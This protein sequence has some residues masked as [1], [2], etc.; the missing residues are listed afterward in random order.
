MVVPEVVVPEALVL[1]NFDKYS[2]KRLLLELLELLELELSELD[3]P[4][5]EEMES[6][7]ASSEPDDD[8]AILLI[9]SHISVS[10]LELD[11]A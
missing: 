2:D 11:I 3:I 7:T 8:V 10:S 6:Q 4:K 5:E 9:I 1:L